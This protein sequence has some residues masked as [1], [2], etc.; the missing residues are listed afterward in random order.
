MSYLFAKEELPMALPN[1]S[2]VNYQNQGGYACDS[3]ILPTVI[4][5]SVTA[6]KKGS[7]CGNIC[8]R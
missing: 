6:T 8:S 2:M 3:G 4:D 1:L 7:G 5:Y